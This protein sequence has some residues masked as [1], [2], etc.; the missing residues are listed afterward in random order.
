MAIVEGIPTLLVV[1][2]GLQLTLFFALIAV[3]FIR[4][5]M[6]R[7]SY[8]M[9]PQAIRILRPLKFVL[10]AIGILAAV[11]HQNDV[12]QGAVPYPHPSPNELFL[13]LAVGGVTFVIGMHLYK[14][15]AIR[16]GWQ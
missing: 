15:I 4:E 2:I 11:S 9:S 13:A 1:V 8:L 10:I 7:S 16:R 6:K 12:I 14:R 3:G 5:Q